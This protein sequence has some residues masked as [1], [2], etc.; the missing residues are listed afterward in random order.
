[1]L[2]PK[3]AV[4][5]STGWRNIHLELYQQPKFST[6]E[7][8]HCLHAIAIG[9]PDSS[10]LCATGDRWLDSKRGLE[11]RQAGDLAIIAAG[12]SHRCSWNSAAQFMVLALEP[13]LLKQVGQ[14]WVNPDRIEL[15]PRS[16][17]AQDP[18]IQTIIS[19]LKAEVETGGLGGQLLVDSLTTALVIHLLRH[20]CATRP[21]LSNYVGVFLQSLIDKG[22]EG[23]VWSCPQYPDAIAQK[24][25]SAIAVN[26]P[27]GAELID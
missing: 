16:M 1:M 22:I 10:G 13:E 19:T 8:Q 27:R 18:L 15:I 14:D 25:A 24:L 4:F 21:K 3:P 12:V 6:A 11:R 9:L 26:H 2:L 23:T 17:T 5:S 20:Y 7:H